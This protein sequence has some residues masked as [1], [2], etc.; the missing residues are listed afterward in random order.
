MGIS[1]AAPATIIGA[2]IVGLAL[3]LLESLRPLLVKRIQAPEAQVDW[4]IASINVTLIPVM[5]L[6]GLLIDR[7]GVREVFFLGSF[8][9]AAGFCVLAS[10]QNPRQALTAI[11]LL[12]AGGACLNNSSSI[13]MLAAFFPNYPVASQNLGHVFFALGALAAPALARQLTQWLDF[14]RT[15]YAIAIFSL[16]PAVLAV[17]TQGDELPSAAG[18]AQA[19]VLHDPI[20]WL[21]ALVYFVYGP[22]EDSVAIW[23]PRYLEDVGFR[24]WRA[25]W[26]LA[27]FW[28]S[29]LTGRLLAAFLF[30]HDLVS[31]A[32]AWSIVLL[33]L[34][35][36]VVIGNLVG[37]QSRSNAALGIALMGLV[38]GPI[39]PTLA[40]VLFGHFTEQ[41]GTSFGAMVAAGALGRLF[42]PPFLAA[43]G[44]RKTVRQTMLVPIILALA[45]ALGAIVLALYSQLR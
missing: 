7:I 35:A 45:L 11:L 43:Y 25:T 31:S 29:F 8:F 33:G 40:G 42:I 38:L 12:G 21:C 26:L 17:F 18:P 24:E 30:N 15:L 2:F 23:A 1:S 34:L 5:L 4:L 36:A 9:L 16:L 28:L 19:Q 32:P 44:R 14:R 27:C 20:L 41:R 39:F 3:V 10:A 22:L 13:L 6:S 37:A